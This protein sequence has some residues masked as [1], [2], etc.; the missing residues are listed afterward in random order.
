MGAVSVYFLRVMSV[1]TQP[2]L[3]NVYSAKFI[4]FTKFPVLYSEFAYIM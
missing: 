3:F 4:H 2:A 1:M